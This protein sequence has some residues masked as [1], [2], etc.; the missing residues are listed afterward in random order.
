LIAI[1]LG[2]LRM[3]ICLR[4]ALAAGMLACAPGATLAHHS[5]A[6]SFDPTRS[7]QV[8]GE[9]VEWRF[10][11]PHALL[12]LEGIAV[13]NGTPDSA[14]QRWEIE[15]SAAASMRAMG[16]DESTLRPG[17]RIKVTGMPHRNP[18]LPRM[19]AFANRGS[20]LAEDGSPFGE[21]AFVEGP[22]AA[23]VAPDA[24]GAKRLAG[25]WR[26]P[27]QPNGR[28]APLA[29]T[30]AGQR[31][32]ESYDQK[33]SPANTC[34]SMSIPDIYNAPS[35]VVTIEI[36]EDKA[37]VRN[38]AYNVTRTV[39][40]NGTEASADSAGKFGT[41]RGRIEGAVLMIESRGYPASAWGLG[42]AT[43]IMGGGADVPSSEQKTV[44]ERFSASDNG[45]TLIYEYTVAD[46]VY[47][48]EPFSHRVEMARL[49]AD[50]A[51][52][53]YDC[54]VESASQFSRD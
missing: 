17:V 25:H 4:P 31:A 48:T 43:Q 39:P 13:R 53:T 28:T 23:A 26:P 15:T 52:Y 38:Q 19:N 12:V 1:D 18:A 41:V 54:D 29:L 47:L 33:R 9:V 46:P 35:Y 6:G 37:V 45:L 36:D 27:L 21:G 30:A 44:I 2:R 42:A 34:E 5:I 24:V 8:T 14:P 40:L 7:I 22:R 3:T 10:R 20:F 51:F 16:I 11:N 49:P 50:T 32:W